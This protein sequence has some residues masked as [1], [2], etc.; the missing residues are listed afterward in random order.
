MLRYQRSLIAKNL[1]PEDMDTYRFT[2][3]TRKD[4]ISFSSH[5]DAMELLI[6]IGDVTST[7]P[8]NSGLDEKFKFSYSPAESFKK[9]SKETQV[10]L[11][12]LRKADIGML[13]AGTLLPLLEHRT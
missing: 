6:T 2:S 7:P 1:F 12:L 4:Y 5:P 13:G 10:F 9:L 8:P 11:L 3:I